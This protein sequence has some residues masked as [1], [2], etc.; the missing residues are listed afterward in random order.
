MNPRPPL[1]RQVGLV[2]KGIPSGGEVGQ[3]QAVNL[4]A[5]TCRVDFLHKGGFFFPALFPLPDTL[6]KG[7]GLAA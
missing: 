4:A 5:V 2:G 1:F 3:L 7:F 6:E